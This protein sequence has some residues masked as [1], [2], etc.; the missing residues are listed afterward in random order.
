MKIHYSMIIVV[1]LFVILV[2]IQY[3]L[4]KIYKT[5]NEMKLLM[6]KDRLRDGKYD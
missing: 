5:L 1:M 3:T 2:S 6:Y 4:N